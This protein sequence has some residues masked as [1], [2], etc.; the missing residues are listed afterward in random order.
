MNMQHEILKIF[1]LY[2]FSYYANTCMYLYSK[3]R[4]P[5]KEKKGFQNHEKICICSHLPYTNYWEQSVLNHF[6]KKYIKH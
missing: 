4:S 5:N 2:Q 6:N 1:I 3:R